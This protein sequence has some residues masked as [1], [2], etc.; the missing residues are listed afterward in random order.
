MQQRLPEEVKVDAFGDRIDLSRR[1][2]AG[3]VST[4]ALYL[5]DIGNAEFGDLCPLCTARLAP[6]P[7]GRL[8]S[9]E[10]VPQYTLGGVIR[11]RTCLN[12]NGRGALAEDELLRWWTQEYPARFATP[13]LPGSRVGGDVL[14]RTTTNGKFTLVVSGG[15]ADG[16]HD[17]LTTAGLTE[18]VTVSLS[19][20]T[21]AWMVALLKSAYLAACIHL[22]EV[23]LTRD[24]QYAREVIRAGAF[25]TGSP[26]VGCGSDSVPFRVFRIYGATEEQARGVWIGTAL[27]PWPS[28]NVPI[29]GVGLG[30]VAFV[31]WPIPDLRQRAVKLAVASSVA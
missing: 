13:G 12:C 26:V 27:L 17:V 1:P 28:G 7:A 2:G 21:G 6:T 9:A 11:T 5:C 16:V 19:L 29:F 18:D 30:A 8:G 14:L 25:G 15:A 23:P 22:G 4:G 10:H 24:A 31:T 20:A 3:E